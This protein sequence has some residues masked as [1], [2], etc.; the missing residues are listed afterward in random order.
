M[1]FLLDQDVYHITY[2]LLIQNRF[3]VIRVRELGLEKSSDREIL[4]EALNR[5]R[6]IITRDKDFGSLI[7]F[8]GLEC[9]GII[10][11]RQRPD[12]INK[13]HDNLLNLFKEN[14]SEK[15]QCSFVTVES[16]KYRLRHVPT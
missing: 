12:N 11:L 15:L 10:L 7:F 14:T 4:K 5:S 3:D 13:V 1:K 16:D 6:M 8:S 9:P 2:E